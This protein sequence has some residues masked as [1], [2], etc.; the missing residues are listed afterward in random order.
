MLLR[1]SLIL[2]LT[3]GAAC[4]QPALVD[5]ATLKQHCTSDYL[6]YCGNLPPDGPEVQACFR[7]N[8][9]KLSPDCQAAITGYVKAQRRG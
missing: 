7:Q 3:A 6:T 9:A 8:K 4:A 5:R 1:S 2:I